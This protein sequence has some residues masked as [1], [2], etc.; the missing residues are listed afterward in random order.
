MASATVKPSIIKHDFQGKIFDSN[1]AEIDVEAIEM[2]QEDGKLQN[3]IK[4]VSVKKSRDELFLSGKGNWYQTYFINTASLKVVEED[5]FGFWL[6]F[7]RLIPIWRNNI[8]VYLGVKTCEVFLCLVAIVKVR[9]IMLTSNLFP[10]LNYVTGECH[11]FLHRGWPQYTPKR[12]FQYRN[13]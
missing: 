2:H 5:I 3:E 9:S 6:T 12:R 11:R 8:R 7:L 13:V 4:L 1:C 10:L